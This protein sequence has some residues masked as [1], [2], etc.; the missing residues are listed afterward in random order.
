M[1]KVSALSLILSILPHKR[2]TLNCCD[3]KYHKHFDQLHLIQN[4]VETEVFADNR[5]KETIKAVFY[6]VRSYS[7]HQIWCTL[8]L[9]FG[10]AIRALGKREYLTFFF[11]YFSSKPYDVAPHLNRLVKMIQMRGHNKIFMQNEQKLSLIITKYS[12]LSRTLCLKYTRF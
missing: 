6:V 9:S 10:N 3:L 11:F 1:N 12:L 4:K 7:S 2:D 8:G 5:I